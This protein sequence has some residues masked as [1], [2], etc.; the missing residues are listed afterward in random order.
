[1]GGETAASMSRKVW[2]QGGG[3]AIEVSHVLRDNCRHRR[4]AISSTAVTVVHLLTQFARCTA[5]C[6]FA[7][8]HTD[9]KWSL[10]VHLF[11]K[12]LFHQD[13]C[14]CTLSYLFT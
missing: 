4:R 9:I 12:Y 6:A 14:G 1:M 13:V 11:F 2:E 8:V 3:H 10:N 5:P 7:P